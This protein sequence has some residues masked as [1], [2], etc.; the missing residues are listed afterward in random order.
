MQV[1]ECIGAFTFPLVIYGKY[2]D[3]REPLDQRY[4]EMCILNSKELFKRT[5]LRVTSMYQFIS[6]LHKFNT[7]LSNLVFF[8]IVFVLKKF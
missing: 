1:I 8:S 4:E 3:H 5:N 6:V 2:S 7:P